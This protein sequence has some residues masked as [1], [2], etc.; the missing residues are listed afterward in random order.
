MI[1]FARD[2][3]GGVGPLGM[4]ALPCFARAHG[5]GHPCP[6]VHSFM[7]QQKPEIIRD[8]KKRGEW[9]EAVFA[10]RTAENGLTVSKPFGR[11]GEF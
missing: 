9:A 2:D 10:A 4:T 5:W 6:R 7:K 8:N 1:F 3:R 11:F